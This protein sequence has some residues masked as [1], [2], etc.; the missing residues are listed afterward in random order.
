MRRMSALRSFIDIGANLTDGMYQGMY[1]G[2]KKHDPDLDKVLKR[3]W[4]IGMEK[5][6]VTGGSV[7]DS[8]NALEICKLDSRLFSTVGCHPTRCNDFVANPE[9]YLSDMR[10]LI[11]ENRDKVVALGELG[12]DYDRLHFCSKDVQ[13]K[14]F[15]YQLQLSGEF[16]LPMFLH[17]RA[18]ADDLV[19][20]LSRNM[21]IVN[22]NG[23]VVHSFDGTYDAMQKIIDLG[24]HIG[25]NGCSLRSQDNLDVASKIPQNRL[26]IETDCPW[27]EVKPTHPGY[28]HVVTKFPSVKKEKYSVDSDCQVKG[29]NEP[30]NIVQVL[31]ILAAIRNED[32]DELAK[33]IYR[34]TNN[35][36]FK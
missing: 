36:F 6:I 29:R 2:S 31:E 16:K 24:L 22:E 4:D 15:E 30:V 33:A 34:N 12:L 23:G 8:K 5:M 7:E 32:I 21:S 10:T 3:S 25:I 19:E 13:L 26:L 17:C 35:L 11:S 18:A 9:A 28:K 27:C 20:I 1:H 14:Y